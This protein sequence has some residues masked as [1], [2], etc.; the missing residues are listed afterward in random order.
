MTGSGTPLRANWMSGEH[1]N[2]TKKKFGVEQRRLKGESCGRSDALEFAAWI[3]ATNYFD[4]TG[5]G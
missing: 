5:M 3:S 2:N 4:Q 1:G